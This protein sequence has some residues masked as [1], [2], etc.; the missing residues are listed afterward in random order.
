MEAWEFGIDKL[1]IINNYANDLKC[2]NDQAH[3]F[4]V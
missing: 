4:H 3:A 2:F 1:A